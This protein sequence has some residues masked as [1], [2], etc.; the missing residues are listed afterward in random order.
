MKKSL[1]KVLTVMLSLF[2]AV[3]LF[4]GCATS[5]T[6]QPQGQSNGP[7]AGGSEKPAQD[8]NKEEVVHFLTVRNNDHA[9]SKTIQAI[10]EK[11]QQE[12]NPKFS[13]EFDVIVDRPAQEQKV[14]TLAASGNLPE[15]FEI[16]PNPYLSQ[17]IGK[18]M[19]INIGDLFDELGVTDEFLDFPLEYERTK[20]GLYLMPMESNAEFFWYN[21]QMFNDAGVTP[22]E[23]FDEFLDVCKKL[24]EAGHTP[25]AVCGVDGW[26][27]IRYFSFLPFRRTV[28]DFIQQAIRGDVSFKSEVGMEALNFVKELGQYFQE[29]FANMDYTATTNLFLGGKVAMY[30]IGTWEVN[31]MAEAN[32]SGVMQDNI[33]YFVLPTVEGSPTP[34][35]D[36]V[37]HAGI[38]TAITKDKF[39]EGQKDFIKYWWEHYSETAIEV[40][41]FIPS[42]KA[43]PKEDSSEF[44]KRAMEDMKKIKEPAQIWDVLQDPV[45]KVLF[46][47]ELSAVALGIISPE[48][49][50]E[51]A[52][53]TVEENASK[54]FD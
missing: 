17:L 5:G 54:Y 27:M 2:V 47:D 37:A 53:K 12:V 45:S 34:Y 43:T 30:Y 11:Y 21:K 16:D 4:A 10:V 35:T 26:P 15:W 49:F 41:G 50:A 32:K 46:E 19:L 1:L 6:Q 38:G 8:S 40:G 52:D 33:D 14:K 48:E 18:D 13:V 36:S 24:K 22:P 9:I 29:G 42:T 7:S 23:T 3:S 25:I 39:T 51:K 20:E 44:L 31:N 28:N